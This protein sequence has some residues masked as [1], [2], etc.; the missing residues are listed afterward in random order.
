ML[1]QSGAVHKSPARCGIW[2]MHCFLMMTIFQLIN[3]VQICLCMS[4]EFEH[5]LTCLQTVQFYFFSNSTENSDDFYNAIKKRR[6]HE[7]SII[8]RATNLSIDWIIFAEKNWSTTKFDEKNIARFVQTN[9]SSKWVRPKHT[10]VPI[11]T[12]L[13]SVEHTTLYQNIHGKL[14]RWFILIHRSVVIKS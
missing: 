2:K 3:K 9:S 7:Y 10:W 6:K 8:T 13:L 4:A 14:T 5:P 11:W 12:T 1:I